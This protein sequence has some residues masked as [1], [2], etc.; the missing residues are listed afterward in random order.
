[1]TAL[2]PYQAAVARALSD[3]P[4]RAHMLQRHPD[5]AGVFP[6]LGQVPIVLRELQHLGYAMFVH[7]GRHEGCGWTLGLSPQIIDAE[8]TVTE[9]PPT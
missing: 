3:I 2:M 5:D 6:A 8:I 1:M 4:T 7:L 9:V